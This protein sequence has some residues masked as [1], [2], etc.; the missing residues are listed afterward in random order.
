L[1]FYRL[2]YV[3]Y[4]KLDL[5]VRQ[6]LESFVEKHFF[7]I[8]MA[9]EEWNIPCPEP[10][11]PSYGSGKSPK[12]YFNVESGVGFCFRCQSPYSMVDLVRVR[13]AI[14]WGAAKEKVDAWRGVHIPK[15]GLLNHLRELQREKRVEKDVLPVV[16]L[17]E[18]FI[19]CDKDHFPAYVRSRM[20]LE[21]ARRYRVGYCA[22]GYFQGRMIVPVY[23]PDGLRTF[24]AR[25]MRKT[26]HLAK[27]KKV[28]G[29]K[30][31]KNSLALFNYQA[32]RRHES[33][34]LVEGVFDAIYGGSNFL[35]LLGTHISSYQ[36][37]LIRQSPVK[38]VVVL[39]DAD[40]RY[41]AF[42]TARALGMA[43]P[44][45]TVRVAYV[46]RDPDEI[47]HPALL[48]IVKRARLPSVAA[49][50]QKS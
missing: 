34:V 29:P 47:A 3:N 30:G 9:G 26:P 1:R 15:E 48:R 7:P 5:T 12:L 21:S 10:S 32:L 28:L 46:K 37:D 17:P 16:E 43:L 23:M 41:K 35:A 44:R 27:T 33:I 18:E 20:T 42:K 6:E 31:A 36:V 22:H 39:F 25:L 2:D 38:D 45:A 40:A 8:H 14:S 13:L 11:C 24:V 19:P 50:L 4:Q 49:V